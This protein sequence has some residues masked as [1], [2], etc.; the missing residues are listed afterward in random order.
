MACQASSSCSYC[1]S[2]GSPTILY[3]RLNSSIYRQLER[4][5]RGKHLFR[6][7]S[8]QTDVG[9]ASCTPRTLR[10]HLVYRIGI[11]ILV[12]VLPISAQRSFRDGAF[13]TVSDYGVAVGAGVSAVLR[14]RL[15]ARFLSVGR[16]REDY[17]YGPHPRQ[18]APSST[19]TM[20]HHVCVC[21][22][23]YAC[24]VCTMSSSS[25]RC[26]VWRGA[27]MVLLS[28]LMLSCSVC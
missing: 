14:P 11:L 23:Q 24:V 16:Q 3:L 27:G 8:P 26:A 20:Q 15:A 6:S 28:K 2:R 25:R 10:Y 22:I 1:C 7:P 21:T 4:R 5:K 19:C 17:R 12:R 18:V 9:S 13:R